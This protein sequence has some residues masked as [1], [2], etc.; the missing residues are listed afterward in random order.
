MTVLRSMADAIRHRGPDDDGYFNSPQA[1]LA[2]RRLS[3]IDL[4]GGHQPMSSDDGKIQIVF[5]GEI[6]NFRD[7]RETLS[8]KGHVFRTQSDTEVVLRQFEESGLDGIHRLNGMFAI[9]IWD[10]RTGQLSLVRDR[11]GVKPLY[12]YWDGRR[13]LFASEIKALL[14]SGWVEREVDPRSVWDYLTFRYVPGPRSIWKRIFKLPPGHWLT[15]SRKSPG[16][17]VSRYWDIPYP[18]M[19]RQADDHAF[20]EEFASLFVDAVN[21]RMIADVPVG[22][23]LSGGLDSAAVA[24]VISRGP[25]ARLSTFS[26]AFA[27]APEIDERPYARIVAQHIGATHEEI[28][29]DDRQFTDFI[30]DLVTATDEP[31]ADL[32]SV[33][34]YFVCK[35][36]RKKVTVAL[37][38]EGSDEILGGYSFDQLAREW[39]AASSRS[40]KTWMERARGLFSTAPRGLDLSA[41]V[42][43]LHMTNYLDSEA[44]R[45]LMRGV[46]YPDSMEIVREAMACVGSREPLHQALYAYCQNWLVEDLLMKADK[47]SMANSLEVRTPFLDYRLVEWAS[48]TPTWIKV[49]PDS[50]GRLVTK[51]ALRRFAA[52]YLPRSIIDRPKQG[53]PVPVYD[54]LSGRLK[55]WASDLLRGSE[56][57]LHRLFD[58][59]I[60]DA[61]LVAGTMDGASMPDRHRIANLAILEQWMRAWNA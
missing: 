5:N 50:D 9:A 29:I 28:V 11:M 27:D 12:Y 14:A 24:A 48:R 57:R 22:V 59:A 42:V 60:V 39:A 30:P 23:L 26:V 2:M 31:L 20:D 1:G 40:P 37:S 38:G 36:A 47:M 49:G 43:P 8:G 15:I 19:P 21:I 10:G 33:P 17:M 6:F 46:S 13:L 45:G 7:L 53:F 4:S 3:V 18:A 61:A 58:P 41:A 51:R 55:P 54:W 35:L 32:A 16:P 34:L 44:K 25:G 52:R 56:V